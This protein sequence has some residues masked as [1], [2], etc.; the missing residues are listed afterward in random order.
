[1][2][3]Q[4]NGC[5]KASPGIVNRRLWDVIA[6]A[7]VAFVFVSCGERPSTSESREGEFIRLGF[8]QLSSFKFDTYEVY[9]EAAGGRPLTKSDDEI[10]PEILAYDG[11]R[12]VI[13]GYV[14]PLRLKKGL[15]T[16]FLLYRDQAA[17]CFGATAKMNHYMRVT[18]AGQGFPPGSMVT[19]K[20]YGSL[21]VGKIYVQ[22]YLTGIYQMTAERVIE[23]P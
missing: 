7:L 15:V 6:L 20:V 16:E 17:C 12:I 10:P 4:F 19:H 2:K 3:L 22:E 9:N 5:L 23:D 21:K 1:L 14:M 8:D 18:V 11:K 13:R